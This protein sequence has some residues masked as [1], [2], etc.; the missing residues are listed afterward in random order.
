MTIEHDLA[1]LEQ[2]FRLADWQVRP[3]AGVLRLPWPRR[4]TRH[5]E[6]KAMQVLLLLATNAG[7]FV[8]KDDLLTR[9]WNGRPVTDD[10]LTGAIHAIRQALGDDP[11]D[12]HFIETRTNVGYRLIAP[13]QAARRPRYRLAVAT[14]VVVLAMLAGALWVV[15][16]EWSQ[17]PPVGQPQ[18]IAVLPLAN[19]SGSAGQDYLSAAMT[20][21]LILNLAQQPG[22]RVISRTSV[23]P[24]ADERAEARSIAEALG[25]DLLLEGSV[26]VSDGR[27]RMTAQLIDPFAD[28]HVWAQQYDRPYGDVLQLQAELSEAIA[29]QVGSLMVQRP[30]PPVIQLPDQ[31]LQR[32]LQAR[33]QL[34]LERDDAVESALAGFQQ[35]AVEHPDFAPAWL[36]QAQA[37]LHLFKAG[38]RGS[39]ALTQAR[40]A[41]DRFETLAGASSESHRCL[42]QVV[43]FQ[44]WDFATAGHRYLQAIALNPSDTVARRRHA[45]LLVAQRRYEQ[46]A[47][48]INQ[49]RL[50]DPLYYQSAEM[51]TLLLYAGQT[52]RA[53]AEF[54]RIA[55]SRELRASELRAMAVAYLETGQEAK[56]RNTLLRLLQTHGPTDA[57][58]T[59]R[60]DDVSTQDLYREILQAGLF[61]SPTISAGLHNLLG[62]TE[63]ALT[64]LERAVAERDPDAIYLDAMPELA[65]LRS[66]PRFQ[67]VSTRIGAAAHEP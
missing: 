64:A 20:E 56:A 45:W 62:D 28:D 3:V 33:Y 48:E 8:S 26:Q 17:A 24:Y 16:R 13:V 31:D 47:A 22:I 15:L 42:G 32:Y 12:P 39:E 21:A 65:S 23:M 38:S 30:P 4:A 61:R 6:P 5:L 35:L 67:A 52:K 53:A 58:R 36:G 59:T 55:A 46:A 41:A 43:L 18:T 27:V 40:Q 37:L 34:A 51:A 63:A 1:A 29:G 7:R 60:P 66:H 9:V 49:I 57:G 44:D 10:C 19:L 14:T 25:A 2:G 50:L 11:R 54:E